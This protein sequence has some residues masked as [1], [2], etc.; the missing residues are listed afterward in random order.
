[1][2]IKRFDLLELYSDAVFALTALVEEFNCLPGV[3]KTSVQECLEA[4]RDFREAL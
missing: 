4:A 1:M 2:T 3:Q